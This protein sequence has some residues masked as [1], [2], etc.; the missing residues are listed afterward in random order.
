MKYLKVGHPL[1]VDEL[2]KE[3]IHKIFW[4]CL[5]LAMWNAIVIMG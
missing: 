3:N 1:A 4:G 5:L 2:F